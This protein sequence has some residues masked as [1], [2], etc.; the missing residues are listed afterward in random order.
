MATGITVAT[1]ARRCDLHDEFFSLVYADDQL[2]REEFDALIADVWGG[3]HR[4][5]SASGAANA[6]SRPPS[7][8]DPRLL[9]RTRTALLEDPMILRYSRQRSPP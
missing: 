9:V 8:L 1:P 3:G 5:A 4:S 7:H 2:V 6:Q